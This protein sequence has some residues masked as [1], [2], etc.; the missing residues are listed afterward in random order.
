MAKV[1]TV[2]G[3]TGTQGGGVANALLED[4]EFKVRIVT[5]SASS[6]KAKALQERGAEVIEGNFDDASSLERA[7]QGA[8]GTFVMTQHSFEVPDPD[9]LEIKQGKAVADAAKAAGV[10]HVVFSSL[11]PV[12]KTMGF[13]CLHYDSKAQIEEYMKSIGLPVTIVKYP[14]YYDNY[15]SLRPIKKQEDGTYE[16]NFA[17][18][19][20]AEHGVSV[21]D[22]GFAVRAI[23]KN[24]AEWLGRTVG[25]SAEKLTIQQHADILSKHLAPKVFKPTKM[26]S[27]EFSKLPFPGAKHLGDMFKFLRLGNPDY[28]PELTRQMHP[29]TRGLDQWVA[30]NKEALLNAMSSSTT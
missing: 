23:F 25:F 5:R 28:S 9:Q 3:A 16:L 7:L 13:P 29:G 19:G 26:T 6:D 11:D 17:M 24:R 8:H 4:P 15:L 10:Q 30:D 1:V 14:G 2:F 21:T 12:Q 27:D 22:A 18:E 20:A